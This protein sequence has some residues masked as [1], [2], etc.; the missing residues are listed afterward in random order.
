MTQ[1]FAENLD[2][3][4]FSQM[5]RFTRISSFDNSLIYSKHIN[6]FHTSITFHIETTS[7]LNSNDWFLYDTCNVGLK[8]VKLDLFVFI[9]FVW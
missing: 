5:L 7:H 9:F 1:Y 8:L 6:P 2:S 4:K 3:S